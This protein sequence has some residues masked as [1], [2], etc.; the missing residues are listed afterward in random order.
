MDK[1]SCRAEKAINT[2]SLVMLLLKR[3]R[4]KSLFMQKLKIWQWNTMFQKL[5]TME[6]N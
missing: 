1:K 2:L 3:K 6:V 4:L 5:I